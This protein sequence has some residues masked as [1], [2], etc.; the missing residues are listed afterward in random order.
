MANWANP[1]LSSTYSDFLSL[2]KARD[3]DLAKQFDGQTTS[4]L[5]TGSIR[6]NSSTNRWQ[7]WDGT[8]WQE[9][10]TTYN[11]SGSS[12]SAT[13]LIPTGATVPA[14][15][16]FLPAA[17]TVAWATGSTERIRLTSS[18][19][20]IHG[21]TADV[22]PFFNTDAFS[23]TQT[24]RAQ[25][26][27]TTGG[28]ASAAF[29]MYTTSGISKHGIGLFRSRAVTPGSFAV[30]QLNDILGAIDWNGD[31]GNSFSAGASIMARVDGTVIDGAVPSRLVA[32]TTLAD[33]T[34]EN[35]R[36]VWRVTHDAVMCRRQGAPAAVN[37]TATLTVDNL[38]AGIITS[39]TAAAVTMTLPTGALT[40]A[41]FN[42]LYSNLSFDW[43]VINTG[44][45][46]SVTV[47]DG[48]GHTVVG[49]RVVTAGTS[50]HFRS[51]RS[52]TGTFVAYRLS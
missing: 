13:S 6:W 31:D 44:S 23:S 3:E 21:H 35:P 20:L 40:E 43:Y 38:K 30:V 19:N 41:G 8:A 25:S 49:S 9:L 36:E 45:T 33:G 28:A 17:N 48:S 51:R 26:I 50:G 2:L 46:N 7:K 39:T 18:G 29:G 12:V 52:T 4:N 37:T 42:D 24:P 47:Q 22:L 5:P 1:T 32:Y 15:G 11:L 14:N 16:M 27:G 34:T 10:T